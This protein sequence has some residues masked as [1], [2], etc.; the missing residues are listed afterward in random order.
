MLLESLL[1]AGEEEIAMANVFERKPTYYF[2]DPLFMTL[3]RKMEYMRETKRNAMN[4][5]KEEPNVQAWSRRPKQRNST[6]CGL[7]VM[8][9]MDYLLQDYEIESLQWEDEDIEIFRYRIAKE[10]QKGKARRIPGP[11]MRQR[12]EIA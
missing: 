9:Y 2:I 7:F 4:F 6:D 1:R 5:P 10:L 11:L 8:K 3:A 12:I